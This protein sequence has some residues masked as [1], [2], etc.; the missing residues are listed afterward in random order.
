MII[1]IFIHV[2]FNY[3][4]KISIYRERKKT[5]WNSLNNYNNHDDDCYHD[6]KNNNPSLVYDCEHIWFN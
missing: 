4:E 1:I 3:K 5:I 2:S 6:F